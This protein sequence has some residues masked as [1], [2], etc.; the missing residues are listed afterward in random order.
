MNTMHYLIVKVV[1][2][3]ELDCL[4]DNIEYA[5]YLQQEIKNLTINPIQKK[6][7]NK[8]IKDKVETIKSEYLFC[9]D[10][11]S[12]ISCIE[13][14]KN[15]RA[16]LFKNN[17]KYYSTIVIYDKNEESERIV[18]EKYNEEFFSDPNL[19]ISF[20]K[21]EIQLPKG[22]EY[23]FKWDNL[24]INTK[25]C[26][27]EAPFR[28]KCKNCAKKM[29]DKNFFDPFKTVQNYFLLLPPFYLTIFS[30]FLIL[31]EMVLLLCL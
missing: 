11:N 14:V 28:R 13:Q 21:F 31:T 24:N 29:K 17:N 5:T 27:V 7:C 25:N 23:K 4:I 15:V 12:Q 2:E 26:G 22:C 8:K 30:K 6:D 1:A 9:V 10:L 18:E 16:F 19:D 20:K 3:K